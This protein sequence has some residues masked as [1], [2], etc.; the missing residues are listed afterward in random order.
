FRTVLEL[1]INYQQLCIYWTKYYDFENPIIKKY[2]SRQLRKPRPVILD[3]A[4]PTGN[5]GGGDPIGWRQLAQEAEA[6]LNYPCFKN[7]DGSPV[8][9]W[10]LLM[11]QRLREVRSLAQGHQL[12]SGGNGVQTQWTLKPVLMSLC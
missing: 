10:I 3:P 5:L 1:V 12:T 11:R 6:W 7:W 4:D 8:S 2:L 9:S